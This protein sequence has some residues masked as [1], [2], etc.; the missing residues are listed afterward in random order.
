MVKLVM[1]KAVY[2]NSNLRNKELEKKIISSN[3]LKNKKII[4]DINKLLN[5]VKLNET[6]ETKSKIIYCSSGVFLLSF[7]CV[8]LVI[9]K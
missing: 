7:V 5:K 6:V 4:V 1:L 3:I 2:H 9:I 8:F